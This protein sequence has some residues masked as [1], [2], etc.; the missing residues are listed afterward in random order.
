MIRVAVVHPSF[1]R[2]NKA[3]QA[4]RTW[5][6]E[7]V[8]PEETE[9]LLGVDDNDPDV[10]AYIQLFN[11][12]LPMFSRVSI[13]VGP[14]RDVISAIN[15]VAKTLSP[16][17]ELIVAAADDQFP[18]SRWDDALLET[19]TGVDNFTTPKFIGVSDGVRGYGEVLITLIVN[20]AWYTRL[21][22]LLY[23]EYDGVFAD[24]DMH[25]TAKRLNCIVDAPHLL[26]RHL[27]YSTSDCEFDATYAR[28]N[29]PAGRVRN[30][31][32][33]TRRAERNFDL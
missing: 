17:V 23:P 33:Y 25:E 27:H 16:T 30:L 2:P 24:N 29:N 21:G 8:H 19:L 22:Y 14:S 26:F 31:E 10:P 5:A 3:F 4:Y 13:I 20:R 1:G 9:Y 11:S 7:C 6:S 28:N 18:C 15:G 32:V 12:E